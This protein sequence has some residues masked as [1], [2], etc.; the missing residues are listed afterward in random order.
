MKALTIAT[1]VATT[2]TFS[3][4]ATA[5]TK[6]A[7]GVDINQYA[8]EIKLAIEK[9]LN[10]TDITK[11][12][13]KTCT[14]RIKMAKTGEIIKAKAEQGDIELCDIVIPAALKA[15][16]PA[17]PQGAYDVFKNAPLDFKP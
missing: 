1:L 12:K 15:K 5:E 3:H 11:Y 16:I 17:P 8:G 14:I 2:L 4:Q 7:K 13:G 6:G 10:S 9:N